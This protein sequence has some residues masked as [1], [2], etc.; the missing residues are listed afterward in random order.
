MKAKLFNTEY[1]QDTHESERV[2]LPAG[3]IIDHP[4][5]WKLVQW[6]TAE[7][8]DDE[9]RERAYRDRTDDQIQSARDSQAMMR[10]GLQPMIDETEE[11]QDE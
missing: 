1:R 8:A 4:E 7:P 5:V 11:S 3:T 6:G 9:C 10:A 2:E